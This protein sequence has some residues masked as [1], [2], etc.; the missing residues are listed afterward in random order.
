MQTARDLIGVLVKF[1]ASMQLGHDHF[2]GGNAL[3]LVY[4]GR[5]TAPVIGDCDR[6]I[7]IEDYPNLGRITA[8][9]LIN[10]I[11]D[12]LIDHVMQA[13]AVIRIAN[14]HARALAHRI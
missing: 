14:I 1:S 11:I 10:G 2:G 7:G 13:R 5:N 12:H 3:A 9:R 8:K 4:I 6:A